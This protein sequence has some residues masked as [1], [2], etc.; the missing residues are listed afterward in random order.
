MWKRTCSHPYIYIILIPGCAN[1]SF[2]FFFL[3]GQ[4]KHYSEVEVNNLG[5]YYVVE[6]CKNKLKIKQSLYSSC[7]TL[8]W[9][10]PYFLL[11]LKKKM[12]LLQPSPP[13]RDLIQYYQDFLPSILPVPS[14][15]PSSISNYFR[16]IYLVQSPFPYPATSTNNW[17]NVQMITAKNNHLNPQSPITPL[18]TEEIQ[19]KLKHTADGCTG[20]FYFSLLL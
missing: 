3:Q 12:H 17:L 5:F 11:V 15:L 16:A 6:F 20:Y 4:F 8:V 19:T 18:L 9:H 14:V 1:W 10:F 7:R 13:V 2:F